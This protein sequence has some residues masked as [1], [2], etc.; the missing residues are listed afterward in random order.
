[1]FHE[2]INQLN[3]A[4][5][6]CSR[7]TVISRSKKEIWS[8]LKSFPIHTWVLKQ[9]SPK[10]RRKAHNIA[11]GILQNELRDNEH[12]TLMYDIE[13]YAVLCPQYLGLNKYPISW[14]A[15]FGDAS[16]RFNKIRKNVIK[17]TIIPRNTT[18][19]LPLV[20]ILAPNIPN[21]PPPKIKTQTCKHFTPSISQA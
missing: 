17:W 5:I 3:I 18:E 21:T 7:C 6:T 2:H 4:A 9:L 8:D 12:K 15:S 19:S 1:M 16:G 20:V 10:P 11:I 13:C 14:L